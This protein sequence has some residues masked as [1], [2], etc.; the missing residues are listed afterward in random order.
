LIILPKAVR[1]IISLL[2]ILPCLAIIASF[3]ANALFNRSV[4]KEV[5]A[6]LAKAGGKRQLVIREDLAGLPLCVQKW[7]EQSNVVGKEKINTVRLKQKG[8]M[9]TKE[10]GPWMTA[11][12]EQYFAVNEPGFV[13]KAKIKMA[14]F[15]CLTGRDK[16]YKGHGEM[17]IKVL[18]LVPVVN[19]R[20]KEIDQGTMLRYLAEIQWFPTAALSDYIKWEEI[21]AHSARATMSYGGI[22]ASGVFTFNDQGE[23][24]RFI[25][26]RYRDTGGG[27]YELT[28]WGGI[29]EEYM[30]FN[31]IRIP[32][33]G[34]VIWKLDTGDFDWYHWE[35]TGVEYNKPSIY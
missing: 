30:E 9:R 10:D 34:Q 17:L 21:D 27:Q 28:D 1:V 3:I 25:A 8:L 5:K 14:P 31:G 7:L 16:Y 32:V 18:S 22:T 13:W 6:L 11:E 23:P 26:K 35:I 12:A 20:G 2:I 19:A 24:V 29:S 15:L 4:T 33:K